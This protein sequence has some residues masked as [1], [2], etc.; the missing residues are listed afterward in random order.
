MQPQHDANQIFSKFA[1]REV[2]MKEEWRDATSR[3]AKLKEAWTGPGYFR[4]YMKVK[5]DWKDPTFLSMVF[6]AR[7]HGLKLFLMYPHH[8]QVPHAP[9]T[10]QEMRDDRVRV[11]LNKSADG[12]WRIH[13]K[14]PL[15]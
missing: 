6:T 2:R 8:T 11:F 10:R 4:P 12:K 13:D 15:A 3:E 5:P 1:G 9:F 14:F 7:A